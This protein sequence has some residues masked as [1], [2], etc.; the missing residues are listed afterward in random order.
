NQG[1]IDEYEKAPQTLLEPLGITAGTS[2][3]FQ[4]E[5]RLHSKDV[6]GFFTTGNSAGSF[7]LFAAFAGIA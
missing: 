7:A 6:K 2:D 3:H 4:F 5:H 1:M